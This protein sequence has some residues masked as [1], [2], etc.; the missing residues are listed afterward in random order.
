VTVRRIHSETLQMS[1]PWPLA[2]LMVAPFGVPLALGVYLL[3]RYPRPYFIAIPFLFAGMLVAVYVAE[4][5]YRR[6]A[7]RVF[8]ASFL[9]F[10]TYQWTVAAVY[11]GNGALAAAV[12]ALGLIGT[13]VMV[14]K[15]VDLGRGVVPR[16]RPHDP[17]D[18]RW[19]SPF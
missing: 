1:V 13:A 4:L 10:E 16:S 14:W 6:H 8:V 3:V 12:L 5:R 18:T 7:L 19:T 9:L 11:F 2:V 17:G 15:G